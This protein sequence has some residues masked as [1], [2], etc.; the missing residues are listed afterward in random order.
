MTFH[1]A[2]IR[3]VAT[4][5]II[6]MQDDCTSGMKQMGKTELGII[7]T[8]KGRVSSTGLSKDGWITGIRH[9]RKLQNNTAGHFS[10]H[11]GKIVN[12]SG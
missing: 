2:T 12:L 9:V 11:P 3:L 5:P 10:T 1:L 7:P 6:F 8:Y 4:Q